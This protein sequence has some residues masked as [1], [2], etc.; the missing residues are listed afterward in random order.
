MDPLLALAKRYVWWQPPELT[1]ARRGHFL[2]QL[3]NLATAEDIRT[4][5]RILG[6]DA[7]RSALREAPPGVVDER[8]WNFW[9]LTLFGTPPPGLPERV[10]P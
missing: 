10:I 9:H 5:R 6:D 7:F 2:C 8:S 1:L 4:A 3:M